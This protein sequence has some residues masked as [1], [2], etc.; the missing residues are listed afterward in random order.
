MSRASAEMK[1]QVLDRIGS[2]KVVRKLGEGATSTVYLVEKNDAY[3]ALKL[4]KADYATAQADASI[5]FRSEAETLSRLNHPGLIKVFEIGEFDSTPF[6]V[7]EYVE[8]S[9]LAELLRKGAMS[10]E[11]ALA[12]LKP[13]ISS[14]GHIHRAGM[15]HRDVKPENVLVGKAGQVKLIDL[16]F[17]NEE[18]QQKQPNSEAVGTFKYAAPEQSGVLSYAVDARSDLYGVGVVLYECLNGRPP[19]DSDS[20]TEL[21]QM[22]S[23]V[24]PVSLHEA[25]PSIRRTLSMIVDKLLEKTPEHR[26]Q[27]AEGLLEDLNSLELL[28]SDLVLGKALSLGLKDFRLTRQNEMPL[29]GRDKEAAILQSLFN[30]S[31]E[32]KGRAIIIEGEPGSG[33]SYIVRNFLRERRSE[34]VLIL[35]AKCQL[36][37]HTPMA[38]FKEMIEKLIKETLSGSSDQQHAVRRQLLDAVKGIEPYVSRLSS[39]LNEFCGLKSDN[40]F[41][42]SQEKFFASISDFL[43]RLATSRNGMVL[44]VDDV[45]W[46]DHASFEILTSLLNGFKKNPIF[47]VGTARNDP[48][49]QKSLEKASQTWNASL[50]SPIQLAPLDLQSVSDII[51][52]QL[53]GLGL[54]LEFVEKLNGKANGNPFAISQFIYAMLDNKILVK[55]ATAWLVDA[56]RFSELIISGD[57]IQLVINRIRQ[58]DEKS[59]KLLGYAAVIGN[60][61]GSRLL[62]NVLEVQ[63]SEISDGLNQ[64]LSANLIERESDEQF[65]FVHDR[66]R[67]ALLENY[68]Q[69]E[70][71]DLHQRVAEAMEKH[72]NQK[73]PF[74]LA[75]HY[76][77][78]HPEK[79]P[80]MYYMVSFDAGNE[81]A[82]NFAND[83]AL[84]FYLRAEKSL[85]DFKGIN[86]SGTRPQ[87]LEMIG[88]T[89]FRK[90]IYDKA[91]ENL[92]KA[93]T[94]AR[95]SVFRARVHALI[96][97]TYFMQNQGA[98]A[99]TEIE[100]GLAEL[101]ES[102]P[103]N[104][105]L[106]KLL[107]SIYWL[108]YRFVN[109]LAQ[110]L[111][112]PIGKD[113]E[114][115][116]V[117]MK[118]YKIGAFCAFLASKWAVTQQLVPRMMS[119]WYKLGGRL[120]SAD[121]MAF[122]SLYLG[123][124]GKGIECLQAGERAFQIA[125]EHGDREMMAIAN[126]SMGHGLNW[127]SKPQEAQKVQVETLEKFPNFTTPRWY[128]ATCNDLG[129][130]N[131]MIRGYSR[132]A[133]TIA[134]LGQKKAEVTTGVGV[135]AVTAALVFGPMAVLSLDEELNQYKEKL[136]EFYKQV[137]EKSFDRCWYLSHTILFHLEK[138]ETVPHL[139]A[140]LQFFES[141]GIRSE[142]AVFY[143]RAFFLYSA[144]AA[145]L[146]YERATEDEAPGMRMRLEKT[147]KDLKNTATSTHWKVHLRVIEAAA[148]LKDGK[149]DAARLRLQEAQKFS[150][151]ADS[152]WGR[153]QV[154]RYEARMARISHEAEKSVDFAIKAESIA[155]EMGWR[156][157]VQLIQKEFDTQDFKSLRNI[158]SNAQSLHQLKLQ[159][160]VLLSMIQI[161]N[162]NL[163]F[164]Q[165]SGLMLE[166]LLHL[167]KAER[168]LLFLANR[169][170]S[171]EFSIGR[172]ADG[173]TILDSA[174][175]SNTVIEKVK[176]ERKVLSVAGTL[177][178]ELLGSQSAIANDLR[179]IIASPLIF[180]NRLVGILT[181]D[182]KVN[183]GF[184]GGEEVSLLEGVVGQL[185]RFVEQGRRSEQ[186][187]RLLELTLGGEAMFDPLRQAEVALEQ[188]IKISGAQ[189]AYFFPDG[190]ALA[191][192]KKGLGR[193][194]AGVHISE[195]TGYSSTVIEKVRQTHAPL[196]VSGTAQGEELGSKSAIIHDLRS[197]MAVPVKLNNNF[198]G[199]L[200]LDSQ[201]A[202][203]IFM[204]Q[205][206]I[207]LSGVA[208]HLAVVIDS[209]HSAVAEVEKINFKKSL[210]LTESVQNLL[211]PAFK[212]FENETLSLTASFQPA[213]TV[214]GD[215][216]TF[217]T[218][219]DGAIVLAVANVA[220]KGIGS[221]MVTA[222][223]SGVY[224]TTQRSAVSIQEIFNMINS[225]LNEV[226]RGN[227]PTALSIVH[228]NPGSK[229]LE[230]WM[231]GMPDAIFFKN[232]KSEPDFV[233]GFSAPLGSTLDQPMIYKRELSYEPGDTL[234][235][236]THGLEA[237][238]SG[239]TED[240]VKAIAE[241][242]GSTKAETLSVR[243]EVFLKHISGLRGEGERTEDE[244]FV[245]I[246][247]K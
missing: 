124:V 61:F 226:C 4:M 99:W 117:T 140:M 139:D 48:D 201:I 2:Y 182:S 44:H 213:E 91:V 107:Q 130:L 189:R 247:F 65:M 230:I 246:R 216:W 156:R 21:L 28:D 11:D 131:L 214:A 43:L 149:V 179:S 174:F 88:L 12:V 141:M 177:E 160:D 175:Q 109:R 132:E 221:A 245:A 37:E 17:V 184:L 192:L 23:Q 74:A 222:A 234:V 116:K 103:K 108:R 122:F 171:V 40:S 64:S 85:E 145:L 76:F 202:N 47:M 196:I 14:L 186:V 81:A 3:Y 236:H 118:L 218:R 96:G 39:V 227:F 63:E 83:S 241:I 197:I 38:P 210:D 70:K 121:P 155:R 46:L 94:I 191:T 212:D 114:K 233:N 150:E 57:V 219:D 207:L 209:A 136:D 33:K 67:E 15:I 206:L 126:Y 235:V 188:V 51:K 8:G 84:K 176:N 18:E 225:E 153:F 162:Q 62:K 170:G 238:I 77:L 217:E 120:E 133:L 90:G 229:K 35:S 6:V 165:I 144:Y 242:W 208:N 164:S 223:V 204:D 52:A 178:L 53:G 75:D 22:H 154:L 54:A 42:S 187:K 173:E 129:G 113:S 87:L 60:K 93:L 97:E 161:S 20:L 105:L 237:A 55:T 166:K 119:N 13:V 27:T 220:G 86:S 134:K 163:G 45:Q 169:D 25:N 167:F 194:S 127:G 205:D 200:Y 89:Y 69:D 215:W 56:S 228:I 138:N 26:Y 152:P 172:N 5:R 34:G 104:R 92:E 9:D 101:G 198:L 36:A 123:M 135:K 1:N 195:L 16:G 148:L 49:S 193:T 29:L 7:L 58:L 19:F 80:E 146:A 125:A 95:E 180:D 30:E 128:I 240:K 73:D 31:K 142:S 231:A 224:R 68:S 78:G 137:P 211:L 10:E 159:N 185:S 79:N 72:S 102:L 82:G 244:T 115:I 112:K 151:D 41:N 183:R 203:G 32:S 24:R 190:R 181:L 66:V 143:Y 98:L 147:I 50:H 168:A 111:P 110:Y 100:K 157:R 158:D 59:V 243:K 106:Q 71:R 232:A 239:K 199:V